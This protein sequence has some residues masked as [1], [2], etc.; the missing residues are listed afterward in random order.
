MGKCCS[1]KTEIDKFISFFRDE[2][3]KDDVF[4]I[5]YLPTRGVVVYKN[6]TEQGDN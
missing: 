4:D 5:A 6:G 3:S 2:I 1:F